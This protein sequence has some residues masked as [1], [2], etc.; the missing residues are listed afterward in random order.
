MMRVWMRVRR[1]VIGLLGA[2]PALA[3][4]QDYDVVI[5]GGRVID[6]ESRSDGV[7]NVGIRGDRIAYV[8]RGAV[9]GRREIEASGLVVSPGFIDLH[10]HAHG[11]NS[12]RFQALDGVTTALELE[13]GTADIDAW[14]AQ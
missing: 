1:F 10:R 11:T 3:A 13:I 12:H 6:P 14:Y 4:A 7:A 9:R 8:G 5:R 2:A